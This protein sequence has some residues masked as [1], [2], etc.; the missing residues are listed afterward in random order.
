VA[1][2]I[3][4]YSDQKGVRVTDKRV[5]I[6]NTTYSMASISSVSTKVEEPSRSGSVLCIAIGVGLVIAGLSRQRSGGLVILGVFA[7]LFGYFWYRGCKPRWHLRISS[8][9]G[10][11]TP[12]S[13]TNKEWIASIAQAINEAIIHRA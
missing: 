13:S 11:S 5:V 1:E 10:E 8:A 12:L 4:F 9:S 2:E 6:G 3:S 7:A